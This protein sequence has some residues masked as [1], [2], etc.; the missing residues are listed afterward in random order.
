MVGLFFYVLTALFL[1][2]TDDWGDVVVGLFR[3]IDNGVGHGEVVF[4]LVL[5]GQ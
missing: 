4:F 2:F 3:L 5:L 1:L